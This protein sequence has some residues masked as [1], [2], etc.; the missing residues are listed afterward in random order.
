MTQY[1]ALLATASQLPVNQ[2]IELIEALWET[3]PAETAPPLS[4]EW[5]T[6]IERRSAAFD[7]G[8][9]QPVP[10][11]VVHDDALRRIGRGR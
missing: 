8:A 3:V 4:D 9:V 2:R 6:E 7:A 5:R 1:D 11:Q 10:W